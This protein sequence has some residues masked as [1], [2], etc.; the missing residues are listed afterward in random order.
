MQMV[1]LSGLL[2]FVPFG[3]AGPQHTGADLGIADG[4]LEVNARQTFCEDVF[5]L[6][7]HVD[8][9][10]IPLPKSYHGFAHP[11]LRPG[12]CGLHDGINI[13]IDVELLH[14]IQLIPSFQRIKR[15]CRAV[16][17]GLD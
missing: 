14:R 4:V 1:M 15:E 10:F 11:G 16:G 6:L 5:N 3:L 13:R 17:Q 7:H 2:L 12:E 9:G 8:E